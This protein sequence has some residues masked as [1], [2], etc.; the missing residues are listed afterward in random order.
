MKYK[1]KIVLSTYQD[2]LVSLALLPEV[3]KSFVHTIFW[4]VQVE[5]MFIVYIMG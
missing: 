1:V 2:F 4:M 5:I 3:T